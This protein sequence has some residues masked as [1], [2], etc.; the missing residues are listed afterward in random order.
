MIIII[1]V[2]RIFTLEHVP[3]LKYHN[4]NVSFTIISNKPT[5]CAIKL[6]QSYAHSKHCMGGCGLCFHIGKD[7]TKRLTSKDINICGKDKES[8]DIKRDLELT[9]VNGR[10]DENN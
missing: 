5:E 2:C 1:V 7:K 9:V 6:T 3:Q 10:V 4:P 8:R